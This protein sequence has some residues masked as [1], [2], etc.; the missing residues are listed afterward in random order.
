MNVLYYS[1]N[2]INLHNNQYLKS[3]KLRKV[4]KLVNKDYIKHFT[5]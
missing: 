3:K 5:N 1:V 2:T 4:R